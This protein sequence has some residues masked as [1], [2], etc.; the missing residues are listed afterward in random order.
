[1]TEFEREVGYDDCILFSNLISVETF[2]LV[3]YFLIWSKRRQTEDGAGFTFIGGIWAG[4]IPN[5]EIEVEEK[6]KRNRWNHKLCCVMF[7]I[8]FFVH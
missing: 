6:S 7:F 5:V 3:K 8:S 4:T 2:L 1:M